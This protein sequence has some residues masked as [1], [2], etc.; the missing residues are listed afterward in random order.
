[1]IF[2][3]FYVLMIRSVETCD[4]PNAMVPFA[5]EN[6]KKKMWRLKFI[7]SLALFAAKFF[8]FRAHLG[9]ERGIGSS[10]H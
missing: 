8:G 10:S 3:I 2:V 9:R 1:M 4:I 6:T 7:S 5:S